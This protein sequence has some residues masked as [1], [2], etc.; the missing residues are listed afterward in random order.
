MHTP[1]TIHATNHQTLH[2]AARVRNQ[3]WS[4]HLDAASSKPFSDVMVI[5]IV[6]VTLEGYLRNTLYHSD[7]IVIPLHISPGDV[8]S[9]HL[10]AV[11]KKTKMYYTIF[12]L[13]SIFD[14]FYGARKPCTTRM[15][16]CSF[17]L[18]KRAVSG[19]HVPQLLSIIISQ[20][21]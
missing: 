10:Y 9:G 14:Y 17:R 6:K 4:K 19:K 2:I 7:I 21:A 5:D 1:H 11:P 3:A 18:H 13:K 8:C 15:L 12:F 20:V 16:C